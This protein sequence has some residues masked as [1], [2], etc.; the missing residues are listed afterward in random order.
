VIG[1]GIAGVVVRGEH[2]RSGTIIGLTTTVRPRIGRS[3]RIGEIPV[4]PETFGSVSLTSPE[5][6]KLSARLY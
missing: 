1:V 6:I 5:S 2:T 4:R 3:E